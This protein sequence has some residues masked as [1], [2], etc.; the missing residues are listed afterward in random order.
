MAAL[1]VNTLINITVKL[2]KR[3]LNYIFWTG[4]SPFFDSDLDMVSVWRSSGCSLH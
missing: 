1:M 4:E 2:N 3:K